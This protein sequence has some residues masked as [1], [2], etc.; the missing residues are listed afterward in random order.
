MKDEVKRYMVYLEDCAYFFAEQG[1]L[2]FVTQLFM[3]KD[4]Q[5]CVSLYIMNDSETDEEVL[6]STY[7]DFLL[8]HDEFVNFETKWY[9]QCEANAEFSLTQSSE[10][11]GGSNRPRHYALIRKAYENVYSM[12]SEYTASNNIYSGGFNKSIRNADFL[13][14]GTFGE[15]KEICAF[16]EKSICGDIIRFVVKKRDTAR[17]DYLIT[18]SNEK[19]EIENLK[20]EKITSE[21]ID[22]LLHQ[23]TSDNILKPYHHNIATQ[24][25]D[26]GAMLRGDTLNRFIQKV[27]YQV[28]FCAKAKNFAG[29]FLGT[30]DIFQQVEA[31][32][33]WDPTFCRK[34]IIECIGFVGVDGRAPRQFSYPPF[35]GA[36]PRM[37]LREYVDQGL[38]IISTV[39]SY[40]CFTGDFSILNEECGYY[41]LEDNRVQRCDLKE[42]VLQ[43]ILRIT[44]YLISNID[45]NTHC[46]KALYGDWNDAM[47]GLGASD[48]I[49]KPFGNGVS[50][51][52]TLQLYKAVIQVIDILETLGEKEEKTA[53]YRDVVNQLKKGILTYT[54]VS[55]ANGNRKIL[56][57]WGHNRKYCVGSFSDN[58]KVDRDS[59]T[60]N[61]FFVLSDAIHLD[62]TL[63]KDI[64]AAYD[65]LD[66]KYGIMTFFPG[67]E[68]DNVEVGRISCLPIGTA[69]NA[70]TYIHATLFS[71]WSLFELREGKRAWEQ[72]LKIIPITHKEVSTSPFIMSNSYVYNEGLGFDGESMNDWFTG[73]GCVLLKVLVRGIFGL[74]PDL[75]GIRITPSDYFPMDTAKI[76]M[77]VKGKQ[78]TVIYN[79]QHKEERVIYINGVKYMQHDIYITDDL[80]KDENVIEIFN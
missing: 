7:F 72:L 17:I 55:D 63:K 48:D 35:E 77:R 62:K 28:D 15:R 37:D 44:E 4:K 11:F 33:M 60:V 59:A 26:I 38:W 3:S 1:N 10:Y 74:N 67:F 70:A 21:S 8:R 66:S 49:E 36:I 43:H 23:V 73:S 31:C 25:S 29:A 20:K 69:E 57:G 6:T 56:H 9:K 65:R 46:L 18:F 80:I 79:N 2:T 78:F 39:Y 68:A 19:N 52:A 12:Q 75:H 22:M 61:A 16:A 53:Q 71:I 5:L 27:T 58:D 51:M 64:L 54:I 76:E 13:A 30:R 32:L 42:G 14:T 45:E 41:N 34:K 50:V 47:D 24:F 40:L